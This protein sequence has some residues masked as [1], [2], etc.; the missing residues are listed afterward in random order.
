M[1]KM[2][3]AL[4]SMLFFK[5]LNILRKVV[6]GLK[7]MYIGVEKQYSYKNSWGISWFVSVCISEI[8][9]DYFSLSG[10]FN[11]LYFF[12]QQRSVLIILINTLLHVCSSSNGPY[13]LMKFSGLH[14][15]PF[16]PL[17]LFTFHCP[18]CTVTV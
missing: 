8:D 10:Y 3:V 13:L 16:L 15:L 1:Q 18:L 9:R 12:H 5:N 17:C 6:A 4:R 14:F 2:F 11:G 7:E